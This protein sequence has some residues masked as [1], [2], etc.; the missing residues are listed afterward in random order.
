[1]LFILE[2]NEIETRSLSMRILLMIVTNI[3][4]KSLIPENNP[5]LARH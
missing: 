4:E 3:S 5:F 2:R 1:M